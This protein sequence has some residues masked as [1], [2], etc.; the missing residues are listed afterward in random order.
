MAD[1]VSLGP[2]DRFLKFPQ[3]TQ[4]ADKF[5]DMEDE[6]ITTRLGRNSLNVVLLDSNVTINADI[7]TLIGRMVIIS[8]PAAIKALE[9]RKCSTWKDKKFLHDAVPLELENSSAELGECSFSYSELLGLSIQKR[10]Q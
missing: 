6:R 9:N 3:L 1:R 4:F 2:S 7:S 5:M 10:I 8:R